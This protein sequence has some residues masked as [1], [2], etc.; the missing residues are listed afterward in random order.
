[1]ARSDSASAEMSFLDHLEEL[2]MRIIKSLV[3]VAIG[4]FVSFFFSEQILKFLIQPTI[5]LKLELQYL[6][7]AGM[8]MVRINIALACGLGLAMPII[9]YQLWSFISPGLLEHEKKFVPWV[10]FFA[11]GLFIVGAAFAYFALVPVLLSFFIQMGIE[12]IKARWDI[13]DYISLVTKLALMVGAVFEM[14]LLIAFLTWIRLVTPHFL[15]RTW[16]YAIV[17]I[18]IIAAVITPTPDP[19]TQILVA[20]P[21]LIL[22]FVSLIVSIFVA[23]M[24]GPKPTDEE[25]APEEPAARSEEPSSD[26][27]AYPYVGPDYFEGGYPRIEETADYT[28]APQDVPSDVRPH[29]IQPDERPP[30]DGKVSG[31]T[32]PPTQNPDQADQPDPPDEPGQ[33]DEQ[34]PP[35]ESPKKPEQ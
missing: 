27:P 13:N 33:D 4:M 32:D 30:Q 34:T 26:R 19:G 2:R 11:T 7:P 16:R 23:R 8:F 22:Y 21:L 10:I 25:P 29:R 9:L 18:F 24:R 3:A 6:K 15:K 17:L 35:P 31:E 1:M 14:P 20:V 28:D 12:G 5:P